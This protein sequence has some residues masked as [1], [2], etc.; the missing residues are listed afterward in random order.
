[1]ASRIEILPQQIMNVESDDNSQCSLQNFPEVIIMIDPGR[2]KINNVSGESLNQQ[3]PL[4]KSLFVADLVKLSHNA[5][6]LNF[7]NQGPVLQPRKTDKCMRR[8]Q[9]LQMFNKVFSQPLGR[10]M[11]QMI[12]ALN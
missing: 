5:G 6:C 10:N 2:L 8:E 4:S 12:L 9:R 7:E 11:T 1:M 3:Q